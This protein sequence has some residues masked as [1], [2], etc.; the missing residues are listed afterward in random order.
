MFILTDV[1]DY[2]HY[3]TVDTL[4][5]PAEAEAAIA[6]LEAHLD[7]GASYRLRDAIHQLREQ[8]EAYYQ[9]N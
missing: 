9:A 3:E 8:L 1:N 2:G 7:D 4:D 6:L 5:T